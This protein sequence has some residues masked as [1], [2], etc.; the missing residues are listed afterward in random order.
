MILITGGAGYIGSHCL[1][2]FSRAGYDCVVFDNLSEGHKEA[3]NT[4]HFYQGDLSNI[5]DIRGV[6]SKYPIEAVVHFAASCYVGIS[7]SRPQDY[8]YNNVVNTLNLLKVMLEKDVK[9]FVFSSSCATYGDP[10]YVPID[11]KHSQNPINP[12]GK[13]KLM[14]ENILKDY[15][16]AYGMKYMML[17]YFNASGADNEANIGESHDP[18]THL[19]PLVLQTA[20][21]QRDSIK[22]FGNDYNTPD[23]T[24]IRDYIHVNDLAQAHRLALGKLFQGSES[25]FYN[26]GI[27][28]GYSV[29][30]IIEI[31]EKVSG[32][33]INKEI[34]ERREGDPPEL[35]ASNEKARQELGWNPIFTDIKDIIESAW[36]WETNRRY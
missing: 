4:E 34:V 25:N 17:R 26:L 21:G 35:V 3:V 15:D 6:F 27:G 5:D 14:I 32:K 2:D 23:G 13:T 33:T 22:V 16:K 30:E 12:Y 24:C 1:L 18:E 7:V 9:K 8:Y 11:E 31:S 28:K 20:M 19:I 29:N 10:L 36:Y